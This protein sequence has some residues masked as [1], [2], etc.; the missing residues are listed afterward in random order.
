MKNNLKFTV[1]ERWQFLIHGSLTR[2]LDDGCTRVLKAPNVDTVK[3]VVTKK[4]TN[5]PRKTRKDKGTHR[6][7]TN[8]G[9]TF[10]VDTRGDDSNDGLSSKTPLL[11]VDAAIGKCTDSGD[12]VI[13]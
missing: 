11:T 12:R 10:W 6:N 13:L 2:L 9:R 3:V 5:L 1:R 7:K 8:S 4:K